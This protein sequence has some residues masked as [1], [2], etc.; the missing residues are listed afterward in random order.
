MDQDKV[1]MKI[2]IAGEEIVLTVP[3]SEQENTRDT[4]ANINSLFRTWRNRFPEKSDRELLAMIAF[5][6]ASH[7]DEILRNY[8]AALDAA[9]ELRKEADAK[10]AHQQDGISTGQSL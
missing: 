4:E 5:Q 9:E 6:Y 3:Y 10:L 2:N 1:K 7:Y 8:N